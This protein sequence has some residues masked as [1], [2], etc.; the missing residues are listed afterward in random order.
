MPAQNIVYKKYFKKLFTFG[1]KKYLVIIYYLSIIVDRFSVMTSDNGI[2]VLGECSSFQKALIVGMSTLASWNR[3]VF[4]SKQHCYQCD[5]DE[6]RLVKY[7][8][9]S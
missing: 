9:I 5:Y 3:D 2:A 6:T 8:T 4:Y 7:G 1:S